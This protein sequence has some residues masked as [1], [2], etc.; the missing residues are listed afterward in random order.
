M[1][2]LTLLYTLIGIIVL[3]YVLSVLFNFLGIAF[4]TYGNYLLWLIALIIFFMVLP[5]SK[6]SDLF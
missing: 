2:L 4:S 6:G 3:T 5:T 1:S